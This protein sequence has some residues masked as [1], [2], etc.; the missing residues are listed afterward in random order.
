MKIQTNLSLMTC[1]L[2]QRCPPGYCPYSAEE[3][4]GVGKRREGTLGWSRRDEV[5]NSSW[6]KEEMDEVK[7]DS[8]EEEYK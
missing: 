4:G 7:T 8:N 1:L 5:N 3:V 2:H 6:R